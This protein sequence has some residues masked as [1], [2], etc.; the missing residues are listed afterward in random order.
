MVGSGELGL[1]WKGWMEALGEQLV[2]HT[3]SASG[4]LVRGEGWPGEKSWGAL[5]ILFHVVLGTTPGC[6][7]DQV[8]TGTW[9]PTCGAGDT[10]EV[11]WVE[12]IGR[13][14]EAALRGFSH[15]PG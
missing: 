10:T 3:S 4:R 14:H 13:V 5:V 12:S 1:Q 9:R 6:A 7:P 8:L 2:L 15:I 11:S